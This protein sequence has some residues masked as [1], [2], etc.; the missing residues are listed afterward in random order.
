M[1]SQKRPGHDFPPRGFRTLV[2]NE[3]RLQFIVRNGETGYVYEDNAPLVDG[4]L[5]SKAAP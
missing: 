1:K 3:G 2:T 4:I 5:G